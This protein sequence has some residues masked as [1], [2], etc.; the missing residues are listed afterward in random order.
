MQYILMHPVYGY[1]TAIGYGMISFG[2][3]PNIATK[4]SLEMA[5]Q[6]KFSEGSTGYVLK[7]LQIIPVEDITIAGTA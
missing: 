3:Y 5:S 1:V 7:E 6:Y 2:T 4:M